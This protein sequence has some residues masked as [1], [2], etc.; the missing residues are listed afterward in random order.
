MAEDYV[1][2]TGD[3][4]LV[5]RSA[6][7][8]TNPPSAKQVDFARRLG[9]VVPEGWSKGDVSE[10]ISAVLAQRELRRNRRN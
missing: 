10:A 7:W 4:T 3:S 9:I 1:R 2:G 6:K 8:R 5:S